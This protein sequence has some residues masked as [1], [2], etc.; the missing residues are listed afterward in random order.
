MRPN[1]YDCIHRRTLPG[2]C[3]SKCLNLEAKVTATPHGIQQGWF[4]WP[5]NFDPTWLLTCDGFVEIPEDLKKG[6]TGW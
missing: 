3:H 5:V 2:D 6:Y 4:Y 1:C